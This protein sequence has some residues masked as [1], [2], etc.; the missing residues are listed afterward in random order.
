MNLKAAVATA[1]AIFLLSLAPLMSM[2]LERG[3]NAQPFKA[4]S[5]A[6]MVSLADF[7]GEKSVVLALY[8]AVFTPV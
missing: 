1:F 6:G 3:D 4:D 5:T 8:F 2:A 7:A